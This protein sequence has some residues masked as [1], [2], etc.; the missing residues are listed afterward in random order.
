VTAEN[1]SIQSC[2][3]SP[4]L[5]GS[6]PCYLSTFSLIAGGRFADTIAIWVTSRSKFNREQSNHE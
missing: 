6:G 3:L 2:V 1:Q 4:G 5:V